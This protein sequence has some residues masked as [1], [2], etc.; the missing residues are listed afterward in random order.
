M[1]TFFTADTH[2]GHENIL[3]H[4]K[5]PF[6]CIQ[7][8]DEV[9]I[10]RWNA[11]VSRGDTV[12]HLGD[13][14][15]R[16]S[17][18]RPLFDRLNGIKLLVTGNHDNKMAQALPWADAPTPYRELRLD[19]VWLVLCH[20]PMREWAG[21]LARVDPPVW[22]RPQEPPSHADVLRCR[23]G[24][25]GLRSRHAPRD[26]GTHCHSTPLRPPCAADEGA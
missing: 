19:G 8:H 9:L 20:Y 15:W 13:F 6:R 17:T 26:H 23:R 11:R 2:F 24:L 25:L 10:E 22:P 12:Y 21:V 16:S 18:I 4:S 7:E 5:R 1:T 3:A 14:A